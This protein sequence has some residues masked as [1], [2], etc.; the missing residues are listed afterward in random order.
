MAGELI[1]GVGR[2]L[3]AGWPGSLPV[4]S[5]DLPAALNVE[6]LVF[7]TGSGRAAARHLGVAESTL[8]GWRRGRVPRVGSRSLAAA[9]RMAGTPPQLLT[10]IRD[11][12]RSLRI[13]GWIISSRDRRRRTVNPGRFIP[14][15]TMNRILNRWLSADDDSKVE[16]S[17]LRAIDTYYT[18][19]G[20]DIIESVDWE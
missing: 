12:T 9:A 11:G 7:V 5:A 18:P 6:A 10:N 1:D 3:I 2:S 4:P 17:L 20:F 13:S 14:Q 15:P 8:R 19:L 16:A